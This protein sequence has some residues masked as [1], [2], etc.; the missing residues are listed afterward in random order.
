[1][2]NTVVLLTKKTQLEKRLK[3][4][5]DI[6]SSCTY[7]DPKAVDEDVSNSLM[8]ITWLWFRMSKMHEFV[9]KYIKLMYDAVVLYNSTYRVH[10]TFRVFPFTFYSRCQS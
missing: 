9:H 6:P 8:V 3:E 7:A 5:T 2:E 4:L 10:E 1:M